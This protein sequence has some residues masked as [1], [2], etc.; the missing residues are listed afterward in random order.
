LQEFNKKRH[1]QSVWS[2]NKKVYYLTPLII[3]STILN[4]K[5]IYEIK[6]KILQNVKN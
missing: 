6:E 5:I 1:L 3:I 4:K 2:F